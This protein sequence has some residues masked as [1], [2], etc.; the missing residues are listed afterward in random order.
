MNRVLNTDNMSILGLT[1]D[2]GPFGFLERFDQDFIFNGSGK[3]LIKKLI[4][5]IYFN[6]LV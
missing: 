6:Y 1:I 3:I 2:Y 5:K 4:V